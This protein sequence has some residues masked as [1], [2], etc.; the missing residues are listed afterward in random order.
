MLKLALKGW[1][2]VSV[3][4]DGRFRNATR[5]RVRPGLDRNADVELASAAAAS[6]Y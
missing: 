2:S 5:D 4:A 3:S 1:R 6:G